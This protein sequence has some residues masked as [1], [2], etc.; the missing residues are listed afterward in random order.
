MTLDDVDKG[1]RYFLQEDARGFTTQEMGE[2]VGVSASA[3]RNRIEACEVSGVVRT[4]EVL[5]GVDNLHVEAVGTDTDD[6]ARISDELSALGLDVVNSKILESTRV[7]PFDHFGEGVVE[8]D[9]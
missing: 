2:R 5:N 1:I 7:Q 6:V 8:D 9:E 4:R 3:V